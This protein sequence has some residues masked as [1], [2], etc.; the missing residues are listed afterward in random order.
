MK[1][2]ATVIRGPRMWVGPD[3]VD[4]GMYD[5]PRTAD[6][7]H[8]VQQISEGTA[9]RK[10]RIGIYEAIVMARPQYGFRS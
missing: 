8:H 6:G 10:K 7:Q 2:I 5:L 4:G 1:G 3:E 9:G